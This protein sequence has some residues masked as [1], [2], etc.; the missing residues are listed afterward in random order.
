M[1]GRDHCKALKAAY[2]ESRPEAG[3]YRIVNQRSR[4][5]FLG[6][7]VNLGSVRHKLEFAQSTDSPST[8][9]RRLRADARADGLAAFTFEVLETPEIGPQMIERQIQDDLATLESLW[10]EK[11][12]PADF[13]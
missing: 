13:Y 5:I 10:R 1:V 12:Q 6:S 3:V 9:D 11:L 8:P 4:R 7:T 2:K